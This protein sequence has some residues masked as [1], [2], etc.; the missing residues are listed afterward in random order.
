L[1][2]KREWTDGVTTTTTTAGGQAK[3]SKASHGHGTNT[4]TE[5]MSTV[6]TSGQHIMKAGI[7]AGVFIKIVGVN[8]IVSCT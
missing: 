6:E 8:A 7:A 3:R 1:K 4:T 2:T 5:H